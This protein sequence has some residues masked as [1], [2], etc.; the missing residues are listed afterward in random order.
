MLVGVISAL[1]FVASVDAAGI[2]LDSVNFEGGPRLLI[3]ASPKD[4]DGNDLPAQKLLLDTGSSTLAFC[5][6]SLADKL[7]TFKSEYYSC[8]IYGSASVKEGYWGAFYKGSVNIAS[9]VQIS[10]AYFSVMQQQVSMPCSSGVSGIFGIAFHQLDQATSEAPSAWPAN[11]VGS[12]PQPSTDFVQPLMQ[13]LNSEG[14]TTQVGIF[15]S[16]KLGAGEGQLYLNG[17]AT[18]N[19][20]YNADAANKIG[21]AKLG[22]FGWYDIN[23]QSVEFNGKSY[24]DIT[25]DPK[26]G[27]P[28]IM[29]SGTPVLVVP[30]GVYDAMSS[31]QT[32]D[33]TVKLE[34]AAGGSVRLSFDVQTLLNNQWVQGAPQVGV[35]LG[36]PMRAFYY[37][38]MD[39]S[40]SSVSFTP[41]ASYFQK[42]M[43]ATVIV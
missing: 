28:C 23:V 14:G 5:D 21:K 20:H 9:A 7:K 29:D 24:S 17:D 2:I 4:A 18:S 12:C 19:S 37:T 13:Y 35:I 33:L 42:H 41:I 26:R 32:G 25:C 39:I 38:V 6:S 3:T 8:N 15:W 30:Q 43:N 1:L 27:S 22:T 16:G 10:S 11:G 36:L 40:D 34:G 31:A